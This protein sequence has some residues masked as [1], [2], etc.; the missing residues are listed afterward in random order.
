MALNGNES[1]GPVPKQVQK[2]YK[3]DLS[4]YR[5]QIQ[6]LKKIQKGYWAA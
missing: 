4:R 6:K 3:Q 5:K 2:R 1:K